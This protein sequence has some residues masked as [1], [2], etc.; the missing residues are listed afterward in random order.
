MFYDKAIDMRRIFVLLLL[1]FLIPRLVFME[2][3]PMKLDECLYAI[4][5]EEQI[6]QPTLVPT[7]LGYEVGWKPP[8]FFWYAGIFALFLKPL[9]FLSLEAVYRLP[10]IIVGFVNLVLVYLIIKHIT[11]DRDIALVSSFV[12]ALMPLTVYVDAS[13]LTDTL[14]LTFILA[15]VYSY[16]VSS[17]NERMLLLAGAFTFLAFFTKQINA[18][19]APVVA[20][21]YYYQ[22][23]QKMLKKPLFLISL[24]AVPLAFLLNY[25]TYADYEQAGVVFLDLI[26]DKVLGHLSDFGYLYLS[27]SSLF[28][29]VAVW[30]VLSLI[31]FAKNWK[32]EMALSVWYVL[33]V[34]AFIGGSGMPWYFMPVIL[35]IVYF[36]TLV[37]VKDEKGRKK[38][39]TFFLIGISIFLIAS[40]MIGGELFYVIKNKYDGQKAVGEFLAFK[41]NV[42]IIGGYAPGTFSYKM[43]EEKRVAGESL[44]FGLV[45]LTKSWLNNETAEIFIED[46]HGPQLPEI[47]DGN[48]GRMFFEEHVYRK[49]T[50]IRSFDYVVIVGLPDLEVNGSP[51]L[52]KS[53]IRVYRT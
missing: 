49:D 6:S 52:E 32:A 9:E 2:F 41:E 37:L 21:A 16:L 45:L 48:F 7:F 25:F 14:C 43:L 40:I 15:S 36:S 23:D 8:L 24:L 17:K 53:G 42:L 39:D 44:D 5:I 1:A 46:Y 13:V 38:L 51:V 12:Y 35:P 11:K 18:L 4:M 28:S 29:L 34:F 50:N 47:M 30:F 3:I 31:G 10:N 20:I 22:H 27:S 26:E 33:T 19:V